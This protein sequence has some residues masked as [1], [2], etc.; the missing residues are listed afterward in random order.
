[1]TSP[2]K[3]PRHSSGTTAGPGETEATPVPAP[4]PPPGDHDGTCGH[5]A[6]TGQYAPAEPLTASSPQPQVPDTADI[7]TALAPLLD[8]REDL[9]VRIGTLAAIATARIIRRELPD[10]AYADLAWTAEGDASFLE[11]AGAFYDAGG[12]ELTAPDQS[13]L[14]TRLLQ[15]SS[16]LDE[17]NLG[18]WHDLVTEY[19]GNGDQPEDIRRLDVAAALALPPPPARPA[20]PAWTALLETAARDTGRPLTEEEA[21]QLGRALA[22]GHSTI[23]EALGDVFFSICGTADPDSG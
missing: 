16:L 20:L 9:A 3:L 17:T 23:P 22:L 5:D 11:P 14:E 13:G 18:A 1:M 21:T 4:L 7:D 10:A 6:L 2:R 12:A 15:Y 8:A 19:D